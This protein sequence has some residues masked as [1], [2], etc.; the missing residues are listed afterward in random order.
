[1]SARQAERRE[2]DA[3]CEGQFTDRVK[4]LHRHRL[5]G[6]VEDCPLCLLIIGLPKEGKVHRF[7]TTEVMYRFMRH[8]TAKSGG[9]KAVDLLPQDSHCPICSSHRGHVLRWLSQDDRLADGVPATLPY[10]GVAYPADE[11]GR[12]LAEMRQKLNSIAPSLTVGPATGIEIL[13]V[14]NRN[15]DDTKAYQRLDGQDLLVPEDGNV[16]A[17]RQS[18]LTLFTDQSVSSGALNR[19]LQAI[20][21]RHVRNRQLEHGLYTPV[22]GEPAF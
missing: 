19:R 9:T 20:N 17:I 1:V 7:L 12:D 5:N 3:V 6:Y 2:I 8:A 13:E 15:M 4:L 10:Y 18:L 22:E 21:D 11:A 16:L 14:L